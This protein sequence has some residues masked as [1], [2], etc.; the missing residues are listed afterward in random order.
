MEN[1]SKNFDFF[2][3]S[4]NASNKKKNMWKK[5]WFWIRIV[6][7]LFV[8]ALSLSACVQTCVIKS[9]NYTGAG[10]EFYRNKNEV[11]PRVASFEAKNKKDGEFYKYE[12]V[13]NSNIFLKNKEHNNILEKLH[14]QDQ[15]NK[16]SL[17]EYNSSTYSSAVHF[18]DDKDDK[19]IHNENGK[20]LFYSGRE[21]SLTRKEKKQKLTLENK[22]Q[23]QGEIE[24]YDSIYD[25]YEDIV[26]MSYKVIKTKTKNKTETTIISHL[27]TNEKDKTADGKWIIKKEK[28]QNKDL[29]RE[30]KSAKTYDDI[31]KL[32]KNGLSG[33]EAF[34]RD[35]FET[36]YRK[37]FK[38]KYYVDR[39]NRSISARGWSDVKSLSAYINKIYNE[40]ISNGQIELTNEELELI[41]TYQDVIREYLATSGYDIQAN[42]YIYN[43]KVPLNLD[44]EVQK[45][46]YSAAG[47]W[48]YGPFY[49]LIVWPLSLLTQA[50]RTSMPDMNGWA[51]I[52]TII[53]VVVLTRLITLGLTWKSIVNQSRQEDIKAKKAKIDA[54]Y[55][56]YD[57][58][59]KQ[60]KARQQQEVMELYKKNN[61]N[62]LDSFISLIVGMPIFIAIW[63][64]IQCIPDIKSTHWAGL[65]FSAT[66]WRELFA[67]KFVYLWII[68]ASV[69]IQALSQYLPKLLT[70]KR[71]K[72]RTTIED[73]AALKKANRT[74]NLISIFFLIFTVIFTAGVQVY[75][76]IGGIWSVGQILLIH[77]FKKSKYYREKYLQK[78]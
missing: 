35:V 47:Y 25:G 68:V 23:N 44:S 2:T 22:L 71:F 13:Q 4:G 3:E 43:G 45:A 7:Y 70:L 76:I 62:P 66:S 30:L 63:R 54:K 73:K 11:A 9:S 42:K 67:G 15:A 50:L 78:K 29:K 18:S 38:T 41:N 10:A 75:W 21:L 52:I 72:E 26:W 1:R 31:K 74:Q 51:T 6:L 49:G 34:A 19:F 36:L 28:L 17:G 61:I 27:P 58:T 24:N 40:I 20:Y 5:I 48:R 39:L 64:V 12:R 60:M 77:W 56:Q 53:V 14:Q 59:N 55:A 32:P 8:F 16:G 65:D 37:T 46:T 33:R 57:R 69:L